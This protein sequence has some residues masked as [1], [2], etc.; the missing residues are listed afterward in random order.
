MRR[1]S[2]K[3]TG[4][5][6]VSFNRWVHLREFGMGATALSGSLDPS[7]ALWGSQ[8]YPGDAGFVGFYPYGCVGRAA[9]RALSH[10]T[11]SIG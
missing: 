1:C 7:F 11:R 6:P 9:S 3:F 2:N 4:T 5:L 8:P 10:D